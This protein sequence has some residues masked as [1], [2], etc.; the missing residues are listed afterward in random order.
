MVGFLLAEFRMNRWFRWAHRWGSILIGIPLL[1]VILTGVLLQVKKQ[2]TWVQ[3]PTIRGMEKKPTLSWDQL[4]EQVKGVPEAGVQSW[5]D[6]DRIDVR[7][8]HG[9]AKVQSKNSWEVQ[10]DLASGSVLQVAY[11]RSDWIEA[12]HDGSWFGGDLVKLGIFLP[13]AIVLLG[14]WLT[15]IYL[16]FMPILKRR[17]NRRDRKTRQIGPANAGRET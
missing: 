11:R 15:G 6:V 17:Q 12:M 9:V 13:S 4:L 2:L 3:P 1:V 8:G 16:F 10:V 7:V 14:L 5:E